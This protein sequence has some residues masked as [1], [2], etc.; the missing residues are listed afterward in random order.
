MAN[1]YKDIIVFPN[2]GSNSY[3]PNISF[4]GANSGSNLT[5]S[6][7]ILPDANGTLSFDGTAGQLFSVSNDLDGTIFSVNDISGVPLIQANANGQVDFAPLGG[8]VVY[9][10]SSTITDMPVVTITGNATYAENGAGKVIVVDSASAVTVTFA[11]ASRANFATT[12]IRKGAGNVV[13]GTSGVTK[14]NVSAYTSSN[15]ALQNGSATIMYSATNAIHLI[16]DI[17]GSA[18]AGPAGSQG[19]TGAT[20]TQGPTGSQGVQGRQGS[21]GTQGTAGTTYTTSSSVQLGSLGIGTAASGTTGEIR[22]TNNITAYYSDMRLK[23]FLGRIEEAL[24]KVRRVQGFYYT[25]NEKAKAL[26]YVSDENEPEV[27]VSAQEFKEIMPEIIREAPID[28]QYMTLDYARIVPLL[29]EAIKELDAKVDAQD[30][31]IEEL[32]RWSN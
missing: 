3:D 21:T 1:T 26:G 30:K 10:S 18:I 2:R 20:G 14:Y 23:K 19:P 4:R 29:I 11:A 8:N 25:G 32:E 6:L 5:L 9:G 22:A 15:I 31:R 27:G 7:T 17:E 12:V 24:E 13:I 28:S 16:G